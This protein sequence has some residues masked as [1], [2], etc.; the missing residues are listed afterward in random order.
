MVRRVESESVKMIRVRSMWRILGAAAMLLAFSLPSMAQ[1]RTVAVTF[2]DL[3]VADTSDPG[4]ARA[5]HRAILDSL[6]RRHV[7]ATGFVIGKRVEEI[8]SAQG[9]SLLEDWLRRGYDLGNHTYSHIP[10][11]NLTVAQFEQDIVAGE[12]PLLPLLAR[13][14]KRLRYFRFPENHTGDTKEKH[15]AIAAFLAQRGY[16][17]AVCTIDNEDYNFNRAYVKML[18]NQDGVL[19]AR[20]RAAY[21]AYTSKEIDYYAAL[22]KQVFGREIPQVMLLH[23]N[24]LNAEVMDQ[25]L[26]LFVEKHYR[27]VSLDAALSDPAYKTPDEFVTPNG[28]MWGYRWAKVLG[29]HVNGSLESEPPSW[30]FQYDKERK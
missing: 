27:F 25:V 23:V 1:Q 8:G 3:P 15:D 7:P 10:A 14:G 22:H 6:D 11:D 24:A 4:E 19:A 13:A 26:A 16:Q 18:A 29:V 20:L 12:K 21:L 5:I 9:R 17:V 28:W 2:D 30:V